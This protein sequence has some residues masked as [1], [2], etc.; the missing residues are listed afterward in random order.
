MFE[1]EALRRALG[2]TFKLL[3][4]PGRQ[5]GLYD[6]GN[7]QLAAFFVHRTN[8][9]TLPADP[10]ARL[11]QVYGDLGWLVPQALAAMPAGEEIYYDLVGQVGLD[12][13]HKGRTVLVG[14]AAYAVSLLAGQGA[15]L[16]IAGPETL[17]AEIAGSGNIPDALMRWETRLRPLIAQKQEA[18]R[19]TA[20]WFI[21]DTPLRLWV[22][23]T[24]LNVTNWP[25]LSGFLG[26]FVGVSTKG[27]AALGR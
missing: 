21:P 15:S 13:W 17:A 24:A 2:R 22:R 18:G 4:V 8:E 12:R 23:N 7:G 10:A 1:D 3:A 9:A 11:R 6:A 27:F 26:R 14:D 5:V 16:G 20:S 25:P 19:R